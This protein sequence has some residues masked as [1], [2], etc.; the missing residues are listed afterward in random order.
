MFLIPVRSRCDGFEIGD[1]I[2]GV[3]GS[4]DDRIKLLR[5]S[6]SD[7]A[8]VLERGGDHH[9]WMIQQRQFFVRQFQFWEVQGWLTDCIHYA[10][11]F[12]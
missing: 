10:G 11:Q 6:R 1:P 12:L 4:L 5:I 8:R 7:N 2:A 3:F 9:Q